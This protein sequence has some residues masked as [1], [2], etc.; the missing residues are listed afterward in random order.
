MPSIN[1]SNIKRNILGDTE[2]RTRG[3]WERSRYATTVLCSPFPTHNFTDPSVLREWNFYK[4][5]GKKC[6]SLLK[7]GRNYGSV[8]FSSIGPRTGRLTDLEIQAQEL[9]LHSRLL[10]PVIF[11]RLIFFWPYLEKP[12][13]NWGKESSAEWSQVSGWAIFG[14]ALRKKSF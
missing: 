7:F 2:N 13:L 4:F 1:I 3:C 11:G 8:K 5:F 6:A 10:S 12:A 14:R 9:H